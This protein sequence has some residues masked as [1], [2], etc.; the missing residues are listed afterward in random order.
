[1]QQEASEATKDTVSYSVSLKDDGWVATFKRG[2]FQ[3][4]VPINVPVESE[5]TLDK[6]YNE[7]EDRI[8]WILFKG[9]E[10]SVEQILERR[11]KVDRENPQLGASIRQLA[12]GSV[13]GVI[14][15]RLAW[16]FAYYTGGHDG[17]L[18]LRDAL[19]VAEAQDRELDG[20][21]LHTWNLM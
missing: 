3:F 17:V 1:M 12:H 19:P 9:G 8:R 10:E 21:H 7:M 11:A 14:A 20:I 4:E 5:E 15:Q 16:E 13:M 18:L 6:I 2:E